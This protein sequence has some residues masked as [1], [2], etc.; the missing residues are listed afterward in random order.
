M[1]F[2]YNLARE[3]FLT[4]Q[5]NWLTA[6]VKLL[7]LAGNYN[8]D[9]AHQFVADI[10]ESAIVARSAVAA[11]KAADDGYARA[12]PFQLFSLL[13]PEITAAVLYQ[14]TGDDATSML[15]AYVD[16]G[17][18]FPFQPLGFDYAFA[19]DSIEGGFFR[20]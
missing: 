16:D 3:R 14:D 8:A 17:F 19:Y 9:P 6:D 4:A 1:N 7:V 13:G 5:F 12:I 11:S 18:A 15:L 2:K 10:P 20:T